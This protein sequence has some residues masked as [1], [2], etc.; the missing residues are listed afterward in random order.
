MSNVLLQRSNVVTSHLRSDLP[1]FKVGSIID[2]YYRI[3]EGNKERTQVFSGIVTNRHA[4]TGMDAT[5]TV[6]KVAVGSV[7]V[8]RTF[9][10]HSP[11]IEKI[12]VKAYQRARKANLRQLRDVKDP[13]KSVRAKSV[14][15][16]TTA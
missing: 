5:F 12:N 1:D 6:L 7:K 9:P 8:E 16:Q 14:K 13:I 15:P 2:V 4:G 11:F 3:K 10:L